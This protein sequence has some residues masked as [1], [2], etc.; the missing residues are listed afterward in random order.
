MRAVREEKIFAEVKRLCCAGLEGPDLLREVTARLRPAVPFD[1]YCA[2]TVDPV[3][4]LATHAQADGMGGDRVAALWIE[5]YLDHERDRYGRMARS[6]RAVEL[7]SEVSGGRDSRR[8][9]E[10]LAPLGYT[11]EMSGAFAHA[12]SLWGT[13]DVR[14]GSDVAD[15]RPDEV[16][17]LGRVAPHL[18]NGLKLAV[19]RRRSAAGGDDGPGV[20]TLD[21]RGRVVRRTRAAERWLGELED[22]GSGWWEGAEPGPI[23]LR[24]VANAL[25]RALGSQ[26]DLDAVPKAHLRARSGRWLT[27]YG[28]LTEAGA[29]EPGEMV[30]VIEPSKAEEVA[31]LNLAA[32]GLSRREEE[33]V[34]LVVRGASTR[35]ISE[36]LFISEYTVQNHLCNVFEK[37]GVRSRCE[38]IKNLFFDNL[39]PSLFGQA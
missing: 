13:M 30:V 12:G 21:G 22:L 38:L 37:V 32:Y 15:F 36:E 24:M 19:L 26:G 25:K 39:Y 31:W 10:I 2:C 35:R 3:S 9:E 1:A 6:H 16:A 4:G 28:S 5:L 23:A 7:L 34:R 27:F 17:L 8:Y 33:V 14:R 29:G 18:C 20:L 11:H